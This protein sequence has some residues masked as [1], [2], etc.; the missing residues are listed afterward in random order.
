VETGTHGELIGMDGVY[1]RIWR[2]QQAER[3]VSAE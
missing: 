3:R 1:H 2:L